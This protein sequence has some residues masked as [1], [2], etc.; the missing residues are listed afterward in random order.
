MAISEAIGLDI[1][2][3][4]LRP[5]QETVHVHG[6]RLAPR[7]LALDSSAIGLLEPWL[8]ARSEMSGTALFCV[9]RAATKGARW[10]E[11]AARTAFEDVADRL[12]WKR[13]VPG[14]FRF[15]FVIELMIEQW[16]IPY[17]QAQ[18]GTRSLRSFE[19]I[20]QHLEIRV[21]EDYEIVDI[22]RV[23]PWPRHGEAP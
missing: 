20:Y 23:R 7:R 10:T 19:K 21:P 11:N 3:L 16:P 8:D 18:L 12:G 15:S 6:G 9:I 13:L 1:G 22:V 14:D 5:G 17:I 2:D 4:D